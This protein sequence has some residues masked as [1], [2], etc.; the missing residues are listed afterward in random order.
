MF[1]RDQGLIVMAVLFSRRS[2]DCVSP[3]MRKST[4][5]LLHRKH[6]PAIFTS[7]CC[8]QLQ[9]L[10][11]NHW[12]EHSRAC[13][14]THTIWPTHI[15]STHILLF[16]L[17]FHSSEILHTAIQDIVIY[18]LYQLSALC[19]DIREAGRGLDIT[20]HSVS[21]QSQ[22]ISSLSC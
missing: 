8:L 14:P 22:N 20:Q 7:P 4:Y 5:E 10:N 3:N 17:S 2:L 13:A 19:H 11:W 9:H 16:R 1:L 12:K 21:I 18:Q 6:Y 15:P